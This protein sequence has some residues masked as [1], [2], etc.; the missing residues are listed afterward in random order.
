MITAL[1]VGGGISVFVLPQ[2]IDLF[3]S[4]DFE[5]PMATKVLLTFAGIMKHYGI[6]ILGAITGLI[7]F[8]R[9]IIETHFIKPAWQI[10][11]LKLPV[12]GTFIQNVELSAFCRNL[13]MMLKSGLPIAAALD[14]QKQSTTNYVFK[15]YLD[16][17]LSDVNKGK[18]ISESIT[19]N[20]L[21]Y[22]STLAVRMIGVGE[23]TGKLDESLVYLGDYFE[24]EVDATAKDFSVVL[25]PIILLGVGLIVAYLA[26]AII[27]P[28]YQF[29]GNVKR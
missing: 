8:L 20:R 28:I 23:K 13:G 27:S 10:F 18:N 21:V 5:L 12:V 6:L 29:T 17:I 14:T 9:F 26:L 15:N 7:L 3:K 1:L 24:E 22:F 4:M 19:N 2:L 11:L 25:E 16:I